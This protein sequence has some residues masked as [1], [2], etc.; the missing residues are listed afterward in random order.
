[1]LPCVFHLRLRDFEL[2]AERTL[3]ASLR[4]RPVAIISSHQ[5]NGTVVALSKE[6]QAEGLFKGMKVSLVRKMSHSALLLPYNRSLYA[7]LNSYVYS[8]IQNFTPIV[9]PAGY[10]K[11]YMDMTG[12]E[13]LHGKHEQ[14][15]FQLSEMI[16]GQISLSSVVGISANKL[17]SRIATAVIPERIHRVA[18]GNEP[19]FLSPLDAPV[20]PT[21]HEPSV[22]KIVRFL[23][24]KQVRQ[25]QSVAAYPEE[26]RTLFGAYALRLTREVRGQDTSLVKPPMLKDHILEQTVLRED[27][28][29]ESILWGVVKNLAEQ[30]AFKLRRRSQISKRVRLE[31]HYTDGFCHAVKGRFLSNAES[32]VSAVAWQMFEQANTRRN[33]IRAVLIDAA[34][35]RQFAR[36]EALFISPETRSAAL[37]KAMDTIRKKHGF[38]GIQWALAMNVKN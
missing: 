21:V 26:A 14:A 3:D 15:G 13:R 20:I 34:D 30:V 33:R 9:E 32:T 5:Q 35:F 4:T 18:M 23:L 22:Q 12:T 29:D 8:A 37:S 31:V 38:N 36:Q 24:L 19:L 1:M 16:R 7:R 11:F 25:I 28:N 10:G 6:A 2:Q 17:V 27:T